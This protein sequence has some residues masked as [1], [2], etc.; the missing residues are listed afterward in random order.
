VAPAAPAAASAASAVGRLSGSDADKEALR[1][2][3]SG[4]EPKMAKEE[5][6]SSKESVEPGNESVQDDGKDSSSAAA[7]ASSEDGAAASRQTPIPSAKF[8]ANWRDAFANAQDRWEVDDKT[9]RGVYFH[10]ETG[11]YFEWDQRGGVLFQYFFDSGQGSGDRVVAASKEDLPERAPVW[12]AECPEMHAEVWEVLPLPPSDPAAQK[13]EAAE[14]AEV[15]STESGTLPGDSAQDLPT[16]VEASPATVE[17]SPA[18]DEDSPASTPATPE[19]NRLKDSLLMAPPPPPGPKRKK[20][21]PVPAMPS[22]GSSSASAANRA[23]TDEPKLPGEDEG[24]FVIGPVM[25]CAPA[26]PPVS[27][28]SSS[29][30]A[31]DDDDEDDG[32]RPLI[33]DDD[34]EV[35]DL[36]AEDTALPEAPAERVEPTAMDLDLDMFG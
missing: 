18:R 15:S 33:F 17:D 6:S 29:R 16:A 11:L 25:G 24:D 35:A 7:G 3:L 22:V 27:S 9:L 20:L 23:A 4:D 1:Q 31:Q 21:P 34:E 12:S 26:P 36:A 8:G 14:P 32:A 30:A 19:G 5:T 13:T 28:S 2:W 10:S